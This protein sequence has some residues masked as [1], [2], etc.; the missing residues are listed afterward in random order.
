MHATA[1]REC[2]DTVRESTLPGKFTL[3][4]RSVAAPGTR[5]RVSIASGF[6]VERSTNC[7]ILTPDPSSLLQQRRAR[8]GQELGTELGTDMHADS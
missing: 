4:E 1:H 8:K 2:A 6:S 3:G 7:A 5:T